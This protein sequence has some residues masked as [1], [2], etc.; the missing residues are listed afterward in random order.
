MKL[1]ALQHSSAQKQI[2][3][4]FFT[5]IE[6]LVVIAIIAILASMLLPALQ[7]ARERAQTTQC[8]N[9]MREINN[10]ILRYADDNKGYAPC[11]G[12]V[13][14]F[15]FYH[16]NKQKGTLTDYLPYRL[17]SEGKGVPGPV[18][19]CPKG[20]RDWTVPLN[21]DQTRPSKSNPNFSYG[22]NYFT[23]YVANKPANMQYFQKFSTGRHHSSRMSLAEIGAPWLT[24]Y[25]GPTDYVGAGGVS[26]LN[27]IAYRHP[28]LKST[29]IAYADG[30]VA[31]L[32][33]YAL[34]RNVSGYDGTGDKTFFWRDNYATAQ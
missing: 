34:P 7:Q 11:G 13:S 4:Q 23:S 25:S 16:T 22:M 1:Y 2:K 26:G 28:F 3:T 17:N 18:A 24:W 12:Y 29:N 8:M 27:H 21:S 6:L 33:A 30:H 14:N 9:N 5:L 10:A 15:L 19:Y 31:P 20:R 32:K